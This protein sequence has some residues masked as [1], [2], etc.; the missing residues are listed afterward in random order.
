MYDKMP[1][2]IMNAGVTFQ[3]VMG[4]S[5]SKEKVNFVV[6]YM[7]EITTTSNSDMDHIKH[8]E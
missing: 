8:L 4:I 7:D 2:G 3:M 1:F 6:M 5:F